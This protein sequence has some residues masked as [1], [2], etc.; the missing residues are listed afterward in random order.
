[1]ATVI[2]LSLPVMPLPLHT[3]AHVAPYMAKFQWFT[4]YLVFQP[5]HSASLPPESQNVY[6]YIF[7]CSLLRLDMLAYLC[8]YLFF[9]ES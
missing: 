6:E 1:M 3:L 5:V 8:I 7:I 4:F 2:Y 9:L